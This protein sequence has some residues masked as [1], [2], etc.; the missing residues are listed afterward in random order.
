QSGDTLVVRTTGVHMVRRLG[1]ALLHAHHGDLAL[2]YRDGEDMLR[3]QWTRD[4][5]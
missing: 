5:A 1:E 3:A 2:N 4:D